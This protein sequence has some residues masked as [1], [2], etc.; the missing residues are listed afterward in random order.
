MNRAR[1][2][3]ANLEYAY[4]SDV[5]LRGCVFTDA[6]LFNT[7]FRRNDF[8]EAKGISKENFLGWKYSIMPQYK[9]LETYPDQCKDVYRALTA[10][11]QAAGALEDAS[12]AA[13]KEREMHRRWFRS[14][15]N[16]L[17][18]IAEDFGD[19][20]FKQRKPGMKIILF[21]FIHSLTS[22]VQ[23]LRL[24]FFKILCGYGER[25]WRI[26]VASFL[27]ILIYAVAYSY[28]GIL[29]EI[30]SCLYFSV[31]TFL[32]VGDANLT[33]KGNYQWMVASESFIGLLLMGLF[34]FT[35]ARR[36]V[37]RN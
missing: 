9:M 33:L 16:P 37:G 2:E 22:S 36:A 8:S 11:F 5:D 13:Y 10:H 28:Y 18:H 4:L 21:S 15:I 32:T 1:L 12:W 14:R 35:I 7:K 3:R 27:V 30:G 24:T 31:M 25:V 23:Y 34:L 26:M 29:D 20:V 19:A 17:W 6:K